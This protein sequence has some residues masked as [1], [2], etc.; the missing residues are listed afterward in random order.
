MRGNNH[1]LIVTVSRT[2]LYRMT[3]IPYDCCHIRL[4]LIHLSKCFYLNCNG[5]II[6][7]K[8]YNTYNQTLINGAQFRWRICKQ[9]IQYAGS[10]WRERYRE[11]NATQSEFH[12][13]IKIKIPITV[14]LERGIL[15]NAIRGGD[16]VKLRLRLGFYVAGAGG[17]RLGLGPGRAEHIPQGWNDKLMLRLA[18]KH[19]RRS[20]RRRSRRSIHHEAAWASLIYNLLGDDSKY[21]ANRYRHVP[22]KCASAR[23]PT[24][25]CV[26]LYYVMRL[27]H[28]VKIAL[29]GTKHSTADH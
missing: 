11:R 25:K 16:R 4:R 26:L 22:Y 27:F 20:D 2:T 29:I 17:L 3:H 10:R 8:K 19:R 14:E 28:R 1:K 9:C 12:F 24:S 15:R 7:V 18:G 5:S 13:K 21:R 6:E 23:P